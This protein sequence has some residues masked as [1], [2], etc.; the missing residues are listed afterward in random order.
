[1]VNRTNQLFMKPYLICLSVTQSNYL[2]IVSNCKVL[3][4]LGEHSS[5]GDVA[6]E[7]KRKKKCAESF[8]PE[9]P[10]TNLI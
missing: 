5:E 3:R 8:F 1:M 2:N 9:P 7:G 4:D 6:P 10:N